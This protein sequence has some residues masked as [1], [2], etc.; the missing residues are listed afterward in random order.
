[1]RG[2]LSLGGLAL[3]M[4]GL[5]A[6]SPRVVTAGRP[7]GAF[8]LSIHASNRY[9]VD[10]QGVPVL[11]AGDTPWSIAVQLTDAQIITY[12]NDRQ[13]KGCNAILFNAIERGYSSQTPVYNNVDGQAPFTTM[14]PNVSWTSRNDTYWQRVD[15][16]VNEAKARGMV[17]FICPA[18]TG[19]G[20]GSD[21]WLNQYAGASDADLQ[22]YGAF[23]ANRYT[24]G[25]VVWVMGGDDAN[26]VEAAG[27]YG[28]GTTPNRTKQ[29][30]IAL[31]IRSVRTTDL[32]T[33]H[34]ARNGTGAVSGEAYKAWTTG[35]TG[36]SLNNVYGHDNPDDM[37]ALMA[38]AYGRTGYPCFM[39]EAGY[40]DPGGSDNGVWSAAQ[41]IMSGA[42]G[43]ALH[44]H[45]ALWHFGSYAPY[46]SGAASVLSSY[47]TGS[48]LQAK[49]LYTLIKAYQWW[50]LE[51]KT[52][53][54]LVTTSLGSGTTSICPARASDGSFAMVFTPNAGFTVA[55]SALTPSS[56]RARWYN[57]DT[58]AYT[59]IGT[60]SNTG[61]Q[62]FSAPGGNRILVLDAAP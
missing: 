27:N 17:C 43:G 12:L 10:A 30:Q 41:A 19:Y 14:T 31:G 29:W 52:D 11:L 38:T 5:R 46:N 37:A 3:G 2:A 54:S 61:T 8:P 40:E 58:G 39:I 35:Y 18:Y 55:M 48:W 4:G 44:G 13:A 1:M 47:L 15:F 16:I 23:L 21:G 53:T 36:F 33:G 56:V 7:S 45:D 22:N 20:S 60:Y 24:Q 59:A 51:P 9:L 28:S 42:L 62:A 34:T 50:K 25:N 26:D 32:I 49:W 6:T 57:Y